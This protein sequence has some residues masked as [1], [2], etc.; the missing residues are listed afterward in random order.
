MVVHDKVR[1]SWSVDPAG[2]VKRAVDWI[3]V[4]FSISLKT[5][6]SKNLVQT[7]ARMETPFKYIFTFHSASQKSALCR[8]I[9]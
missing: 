2:A 4:L 9:F 5:P 6:S 8:K 7:I 3:I 1:A